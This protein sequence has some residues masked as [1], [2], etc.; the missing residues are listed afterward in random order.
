MPRTLVGRVVVDRGICPMALSRTG[1]QSHVVQ[2]PS[3]QSTEGEMRRLW[4]NRLRCIHASLRRR[5]R[6]FRRRSVRD[7]I[8]QG[9]IKQMLPWWNLWPW[10]GK[11]D[12]VW[13]CLRCPQISRLRGDW[14]YKISMGI[15]TIFCIYLREWG[16]GEVVRTFVR[17]ASVSSNNSLPISK[18]RQG[19]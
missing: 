3:S 11:L 19:T 7:G 18:K 6:W 2:L 16:A 15:R 12:A 13:F 1:R 14:N 17:H 10:P 9:V 4:F 5:W 8:P